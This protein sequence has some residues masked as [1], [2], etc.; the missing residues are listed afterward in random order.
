MTWILIIFLVS[1]NGYSA[2]AMHEFASKDSC[3]KAQEL[4]M[5]DV[6]WVKTR[7]AVCVQK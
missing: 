7:E 2:V 4:I 1:G 6:S 3:W 5:K